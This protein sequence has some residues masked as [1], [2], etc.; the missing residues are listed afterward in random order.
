MKIS[1]STPNYIN[2][3]YASQSNSVTKINLEQKKGP[4]PDPIKQDSLSFSEKTRELAKINQSLDQVPTDR[5][6]KIADLK[7]QIQN[8]QY[9]VQAEQLAEKMLNSVMDDL[10]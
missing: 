5:E 1:G 9:K 4:S 8:N 3:S 7:E 10:G 6:K 2:Q